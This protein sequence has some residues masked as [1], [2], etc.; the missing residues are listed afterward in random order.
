MFILLQR[1]NGSFNHWAISTKTVSIHLDMLNSAYCD[2]FEKAF[3]AVKGITLF[4]FSAFKSVLTPGGCLDMSKQ[5]SWW[6]FS[7]VV[8]HF[9]LP[10]WKPITPNKYNLNH[11]KG[12]L[13]FSVQQNLGLSPRYIYPKSC[14]QQFA[15][16]LVPYIWIKSQ[17]KNVVPGDIYS[18]TCLTAQRIKQIAFILLCTF[19]P[20]FLAQNIQGTML[21]HDTLLRKQRLPNSTCF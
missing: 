21:L 1:L 19:L 4:W 15:L 18:A 6:D 11:I 2:I 14:L 9:F 12:C 20:L 10:R 17:G 8:C 3:N 13:F 5:F 16:S 7:G